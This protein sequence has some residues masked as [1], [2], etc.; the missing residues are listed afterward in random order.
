MPPTSFVVASEVDWNAAVT[1]IAG[2]TSAYSITL[3]AGFTLNSDPLAINLGSGG[4][5]SIDGG[6]FVIDGASTWRGLFV[7]SG[8]VSINNLGVSHTVARGGAG[9]YGTFILSSFNKLPLVRDIAGYGGGGGAGLGGGLFVASGGTVSLANVLFAGDAAVGGHGGGDVF[10]G[11]Y[12]N[13]GNSGGGGG[14]GGPG[15]SL[16][17]G[18]TGAG[19]G[20]GIGAGAAG[21]IPGSGGGS[22]GGAGIVPG[23]GLAGRGY[24]GVGMVYNTPA[25]ANGGGGG[26]DGGG[27]GIGGGSTFAYGDAIGAGGFGGGGPGGRYYTAF[28]DPK[29]LWAGGGAGGFGG[30]GGGGA[31]AF[32][33]AGSVTVEYKGGAGG[34]GGGGGGG[35]GGLGL[36]GFGAA[37][38][39]SNNGGG[40]LGAG[41]DVFVQQGGLL[42]IGAGV[43]GVGTVTGGLGGVTVSHNSSY[44]TL[45]IFGLA[46][47]GLGSGLFIEGNQ[48]V[49]LLPAFGKSLTITGNI[50]DQ[51]GNGGV[52]GNAG[53]GALAIAPRSAGG[54]GTVLLNAVVANSFA[55]GTTIGAGATLEI[56]SLTTAG[57]GPISLAGA[58]SLLRL[59]GAGN[60]ANV[61]H[62]F[63]STTTIDLA[64]LAYGPGGSAQEAGGSLAVTEKGITQTLLIPGLAADTPFALGPDG[65]GG[66]SVTIACFAA[67]TRILTDAGE[68]AVD[69]LAV[70]DLV[71][72]ASGRLRPV[73][74]IGHRHVRCHHHCK[75]E[76]VWPVRVRAGAFG[77]NMPHCDLWLSPD[78]AVLLDRALIP[79]RY[80]INGKTVAQY[81]A[82][83]VTYFHVELERHDVMLAEGLPC[84][85]YLDTGNRG[86]FAN[87]GGAV[88]MHPDFAFRIW[89]S[90]AFARLV[91]TGEEVQAAK[92][93]LLARAEA[94][95]HDMTRDAHLVV[96]ADG[97]RLHPTVLGRKWSVGVPPDARQVRL[98]SRSWV[99]AEAQAGSEDTRRLGVMI[100][101][102]RIDNAMIALDD[103][104]FSSGWLKP[105]SDGRWTDGDAGLE[106]AGARLLAFD[107]VM[108]GTYWAEPDALRHGAWQAD[109][110]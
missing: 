38:G 19:G 58:G 56:G 87:G 9:G 31:L 68:T 90:R 46:G 5:L 83:G 13:A 88:T 48:T 33:S 99:P 36:G 16:G 73:Q 42:S 23:G 20:G 72:T 35:G 4:T 50:A 25:A 45:T 6:G 17:S 37:A 64:G 91:V 75:P 86:A 15:G 105:E 63:N 70:G 7:Y 98:V 60:P 78:H 79:I 77:S 43:L 104:R 67:G 49:T 32:K 81:Q 51:T 106:L 103:P 74:W 61:I 26:Y 109:S 69:S 30:G 18:A 24:V 8:Q 10:V 52:G 21:A 76:T 84:E 2:G 1:A 62:G 14:M 89:E 95:G 28:E 41:A 94:L 110:A 11:T 108:S 93:M 102:I 12:A 22:I 40:G 55:G 59:D 47:A 71:V 97:R 29:H 57:S 66:T 65:G 3:S 101:D 107:V 80:L 82:D 54:G 92:G 34:F 39:S 44:K 96:I 53:S 27:G 100:A 85:S